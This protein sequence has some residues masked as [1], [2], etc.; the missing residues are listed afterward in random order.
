MRPL[1]MRPQVWRWCGCA[2]ERLNTDPAYNFVRHGSMG[3]LKVLEIED[4]ED[5]CLVF[6]DKEGFQLM[7]SLNAF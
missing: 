1:N 4:L 2:A 3:T 5:K 6:S 7:M